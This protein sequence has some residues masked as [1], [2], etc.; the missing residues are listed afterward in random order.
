M[1]DLATDSRTLNLFINRELKTVGGSYM[2]LVIDQFE[3]LFSVCH[4]EEERSAFISNLI[5]ATSS[6]AGGA[7]VVITL[8]ADFYSYCAGYIP[9]REALAVH[10]EYI[11]AMSDDEM[12]R[13][14]EEPARRGR[15]EYEPGLVDLIL[16]D[17][18]HE[19]GALPLLSHALLETW[20]RRH[21]R[22]LTFSG[23]ASAGGVRGAIAETAE[24]VFTDQFTKQQQ[25][26]ARRI[27]IRLTELGDETATGDTRRRATF[28]ELLLKPEESEA[29]QAVL[30]ALADARLITASEDSVQVAHEALIREWPTLRGWL[31]DN[32][33][34]LR[35]HRQLTNSTQEWLAAGREA[36]LL[37]RGARL[38]QAREWAVSHADD[39]NM[40]E[41]DFLE[42][43]SA[44]SERES[45]EREAQRQRELIAAQKLADTEKGRAE[46]GIKSTQRLRRR[47]IVIS[48][49]GALALI[50]AGIALLAWQRSASQ[51]AI[52]RDLS[53][54]ASAQDV[55]QA[56]QTDLALALA[57]ESVKLNQPPPDA[58]TALRTIATSLGTRAVLSGHSASATAA[59]ISPDAHLAF[60][61]SCANLDPKAGCLVGELILW[62]LVAQ[63]ELLRW[64]GHS[65]W[66]TRVSFSPDGQVL[67]SGAADGSIILWR[68]NGEQIGNLIGHTGSISGILDVGSSESLLSSS[69]DGSLILWDL[70]TAAILQRFDTPSSPIMA[71]A[72]AEGVFTA[73]SAHQ[74]G[75]LRLW[76]LKDP[77]ATKQF[78][79]MGA[80]IASVAISSNG[81]WILYNTNL[82]PDMFVRKI[83]AESGE[84]IDEKSFGCVPGDM[85]LSPDNS[86]V[87]ISCTSGIIKLDIKDWILQGPYFGGGELFNTIQISLD[88]LL[89]VSAA[90][91][92]TVRS[93]NLGNQLN[94]QTIGID[95][96][97][98]VA[99]AISPDGKFL[100]LNDAAKNGT[101]QPALWDI[102]QQKVVMTYTGFDAAV[103][104]GA[105]AISSDN[106]FTAAAGFLPQSGAP[107]VI[108]WELETGK[109]L[110]NFT[111]F[112]ENGRALAFSP[113]S[114]FL[115]AGSQVP[116][117]TLGHLILFDTQTCKPV[118]SFANTEEVTAIQFNADGTRAI[119]GSSLLGRAVLWDVATGKEIK[120]F[121]YTEFGPVLTAVF[122]PADTTIIGTGGGE[123]YLWDVQTGKVLRRFS[124]I[125]SLPWSAALSPSGSYV[126]S[127]IINGTV[128]LWDFKTGTE[129]NHFSP[130]HAIIF[131][132]LFSPDDKTAFAA[133]Q[134][135][136]LIEWQI[137]EMTLPELLKWISA[138]RYVR[139]LTCAEKQQYNITPLCKP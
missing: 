134:D 85:A 51:A 12:R 111:G 82:A 131:D 93:W 3:E 39:M 57:L 41:R 127:G 78:D 68:L 117:G 2:L 133:S 66:V 25:S 46:E 21:G 95:A 101:E 90:R 75:S 106:R 126:L 89:G 124:G 43:S 23:Y 122:G 9:L 115:L 1:D 4:S 107:L 96:D 60:S 102:A 30:K 49:V 109:I 31:E 97:N 136:K 37:F 132:V 6:E 34:G 138:N 10:Q 16:H 88:G 86:Y 63:K 13:V 130:S 76:N 71:I 73:V 19:P 27:F 114:K 118:R 52:N 24:S 56:G 100:L 64:S 139:P 62:D 61:G 70:K 94:Y 11:G 116:N 53:L 128:M 99:M 54:A 83:D 50:L 29:T 22:T 32:R 67:I 17:V 38:A 105:V 135:S 35:L 65:G 80:S 104:P 42:A 28:T 5:T 72:V 18:G 91:D 36:D 113:D 87:L 40:Q 121:A 129:L 123:L 98:L 45:L 47:S 108:S 110:C 55:N 77:Q 112:T 74:D 8:R 137:P 58:L 125:P 119:T 92:G 7:V 84:L 20:Q 48:I 33:E 26:I 15:W 59:A 79:H 14:I 103:S 81:S 44:Y 120:R 69:L